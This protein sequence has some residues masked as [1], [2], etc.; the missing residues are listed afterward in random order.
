MI[1]QIYKILWKI[2][3]SIITLLQRPAGVRCSAGTR[4]QVAERGK[5]PR[6]QVDSMRLR[7]LLRFDFLFRFAFRSYLLFGLQGCATRFHGRTSVPA[8][9]LP[10][11][12]VRHDLVPLLSNYL[13]LLLYFRIFLARIVVPRGFTLLLNVRLLLFF[14]L[15]FLLLLLLFFLYNSILILFLMI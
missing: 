9:L 2:I 14:I 1:H 8:C 7:R 4:R 10:I 6:T 12:L 5:T 11:A 15:S 3:D 13:F